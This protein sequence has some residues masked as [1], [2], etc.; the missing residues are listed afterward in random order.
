MFIVSI[1]CIIVSLCSNRL[2]ISI[3]HPLSLLLHRLMHDHYD[4]K[5]II[6]LARVLS[7]IRNVGEKPGMPSSMQS[8]K[9]KHFYD[10]TKL[11]KATF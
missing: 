7:R 3:I 2:S 4:T 6:L 5:I 10:L 11:R 8:A 1:V 9:L